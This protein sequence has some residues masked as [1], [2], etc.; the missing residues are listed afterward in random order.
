MRTVREIHFAFLRMRKTLLHRVWVIEGSFNSVTKRLNSHTHI[1]F[2]VEFTQK[3][4]E[5]IWV[6]DVAEVTEAAVATVVL[7]LLD[8]LP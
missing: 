4:V 3:G 2:K 6:I 7:E 8:L 5:K 1:A